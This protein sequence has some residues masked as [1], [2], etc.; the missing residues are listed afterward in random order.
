MPTA[1]SN[2]W[3]VSAMWGP[4]DVYPRWEVLPMWVAEQT[5][6]NWTVLKRWRTCWGSKQKPPDAEGSNFS[7]TYLY[8]QG[9]AREYIT[10]TSKCSLACGSHCPWGTQKFRMEKQTMVRWVGRS[11]TGPPGKENGTFVGYIYIYFLV[12]LV[13]IFPEEKCGCTAFLKM[14]RSFSAHVSSPSPAL[15]CTQSSQ[16]VLITAWDEDVSREQR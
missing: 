16:A 5:G 2:G 3:L 11:M 1:L 12:V 9:E 13:I 8:N 7:Q 4:R 6:V 15:P 14:D 10:H